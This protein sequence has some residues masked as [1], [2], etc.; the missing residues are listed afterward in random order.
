MSARFTALCVVL[1]VLVSISVPRVRV[2]QR[3]ALADL[4]MPA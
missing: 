3:S 2:K 1:E 4:P